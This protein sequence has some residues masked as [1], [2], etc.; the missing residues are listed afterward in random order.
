VAKCTRSPSWGRRL[1]SRDDGTS[2]SFVANEAVG[3][4]DWRCSCA[5]FSYRSPL[6]PVWRSAVSTLRTCETVV[7]QDSKI[8]SVPLNRCGLRLSIS[9]C[10]APAPFASWCSGEQLQFPEREI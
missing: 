4:T 6:G 9:R 2:H 7:T 8:A 3:A 5:S 10:T 1:S